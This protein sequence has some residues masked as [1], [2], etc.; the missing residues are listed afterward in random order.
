[1]RN[2]AF[3][4]NPPPPCRLAR[5]PLAMRGFTMVELM[6]TIAILAVLAAMAVPSFSRLMASQKVGNSASDLYI[7]LVKARGEAIKRNANVVL[8]PAGGDWGNGWQITDQ[9]SGTVVDTHGSLG[10]TTVTGPASVI[11]QGSGRIQGAVTPFELSSTVSGVTPRCITVNLTGR[12]SVEAA[13][14]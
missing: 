4:Q 6:I 9:A 7:A 12:P 10:G 11:Y 14:C 3:P 1:M 2:Q 5:A 8:A 13:A